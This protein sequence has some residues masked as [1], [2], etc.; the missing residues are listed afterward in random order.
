MLYFSSKLNIQ[1][2]K[3]ATDRV[4]AALDLFNIKQG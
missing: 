2:Y 3:L 4:F 1:E